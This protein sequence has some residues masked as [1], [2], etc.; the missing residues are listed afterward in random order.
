[1]H[2]NQIFTFTAS[3][4]SAD[5]LI[6]LDTVPVVIMMT[7]DVLHYRV[8]IIWIKMYVWI[9]IMDIVKDIYFA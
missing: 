3:T 4:V 5:D 9:I 7:T 2:S 6:S 1:M 8:F